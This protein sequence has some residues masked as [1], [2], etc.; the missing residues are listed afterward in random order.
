MRY[1]III[2]SL[3]VSITYGQSNSLNSSQNED[4]ISNFKHLSSSQLFDTANYYFSKNSN[5]TALIYYSWL[6]NTSAK[7]TD[8]EQ[9]KRII[10][11]LSNAA[12]IY[13]YMSDYRSA[14][15][16]LI[17]ALLLC[18]KTDYEPLQ[19][20]I[21]SNIGNIYYSFNKYD[22]ATLYYSKALNLCKDSLDMI[23]ILNNLGAGAT[24]NDNID[25]AFYYLRKSLEMSKLHDNFNLHA[26][27]NSFALLYQK[28]TKYDSAF[29]YFRLSLDE[30][31]KN[32]KIEKEAQNLSDLSKLFFEVKKI[33]SALFYIGLSNIVAKEHNFLKILSDNHLTLSKIEEAKGHTVQS[34]EHFKKYAT[35][36]D[37]I[38]NVD[39]FGDINQLQRLYEV[40]KTNRQIEQ[41]IVER[42]IKERTIRYQR[43]FWMITLCVLL[44]VSAILLFVFFQKRK[45]NSAYKA[46]FEKNLEI[47]ALEKKSSENS[48]E[49]QRKSTL[50]DDMQG[51]LLNR[52]LTLMEDAS[53]ICDTEFSLDKLAELVQSNQNYVS[54]VINIAL[55]KN[56]RSCLNSYRIREVQRLFSEPDAAKYT[57]ESL[58]TM[59]GFKSPS[60]FRKAFR[61][62]TGVS[63]S[64]YVKGVTRLR[65][66]NTDDAEH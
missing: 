28:E 58:A 54:Q 35:L 7:E 36:K 43:I 6:I 42:E 63:P 3:F 55:K 44:L 16:F 20:V 41:L 9:Q 46:L 12:A 22:M 61:E 45:L 13:Y 34:Y 10:G 4:V 1:T 66:Q 17:R 40:S 51:E 11:A 32:N 59:A 48:R 53:I 29:Y 25:S 30:A 37:S 15:E 18:E 24:E 56:F 31:R 27:L 26:T 21:Y 23:V 38:F 14:Y 33:D 39:N 49:K 19:S 47:M 50:T 5:D 8:F 62:I 2:F 52:I 64:F 60:A 65:E 57:I